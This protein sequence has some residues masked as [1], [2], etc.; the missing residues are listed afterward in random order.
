MISKADRHAQAAEL[1]QQAEEVAWSRPS[2]VTKNLEALSH[3]EMQRT[4]HEL[5]VHQIELEMQNEELCREQAKLDVARERCFDLYDLAPVGY[6]TISEQGLILEVNLIAATL[7]GMARGA[8]IKEPVSRFIHK[9]DQDIYYQHRKQLF[10]TGEPRTCELRMQKMDGNLFWAQLAATIEQNPST[11]SCQNADGAPVCRVVISDITDRKFLEDER[12]LT[13]RLI[14]LVNSPGD[15]SESMSPMVDSLQG[16]SGCDAVGIRLRAGDDYPYYDTRGF[17]PEFV[18]KENHLCVYGP[19]GKI[20]RD[21]EGNPVLECICG[22]I[23]CGRF[24]PANPFFTAHGSF[25]SN[26]TTA[27]LAGTTEAERQAHMRFRC[28]SEGYESM[29]LIPLRFDQQVF[30]L[31]QFNDHRPNRFTS[32]LIGH[33]E[34]MADSLAIALS[35]R[36]A[37]EELR[38]SERRLKEAQKMARLGHWIWDERTG[39]INWTGE[40][41]GIFGLDPK[42]FMPHIDSILALSPWPED[43]E[44]DKELYRKAMQSQENG[45]FEQRFLRPDQSI[46]YYHS[47]FQGKYDDGGNLISIVG[48][49]QDITE[50]KRAEEEKAKLEDQLQ[51]ARKMEAVGHLAGGVAHDFNNNLQVITTYVEMALM[52]LDVAHPFFAHLTEIRKAADRSANLTRQLLAFARKQVVEPKV[53]DLN[54]TVEGMLKML[55]RL[56]GENIDL[57]W[58]PAADL[59]PLK[60]D[61]S[62]IDQIL[63]NLCVNARDAIS[64]VGTIT[65]ET[66][67][68]TFDE[69]YCAD[70]PGF[71]PGEYLRLAVSDS[72]CGM[73]K[74][75]LCHIFEP[76]FTTKG[77]GEGTGLGLATVYGIVKQNNGFINVYSEPGQGSTFSIHLPCHA[78]KAEQMRLEGPATSS[79][80]NHE[81]ILLVE[82]DLPILEIAAAV[83]KSFGYSVLAAN[84]PG[85]AIRLAEEHAGEI[86]LLVTDVIMP[87]MNGRDLAKKLLSLYP[88]LKRLFMS[89]YTADVIAQRGMLDEGVHFIQKPFSNQELAVN[90]RMVLDTE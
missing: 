75:M 32:D 24:D 47:T 39:N 63:A 60:M 84:T 13:V 85:K 36:K 61:P 76:F 25:W 15:L 62:Q 83:L 73:D 56:I 80:L 27:L 4:F 29:A 46:G 43:H 66:R 90:V 6:C 50:L 49:V 42:D 33:F 72:G 20:L 1:R 52:E 54:E 30:G 58:Q 8:L 88:N 38:E 45:T 7:L 11:S 34:R 44:R 40:V 19:D 3:E 69:M 53:L 64:D 18:H 57:H 70:N 87:K 21:E 79:A 77:V 82:D 78:G 59:C 51:Q 26:N 41:F 67:K 9:E 14:E 65:I 22:N 55:Q 81:T 35:R 16:W 86:H 10:E 71:I 23:L 17:L 89:G 28:L 68:R 31:L 5:Q 2:A 12:E 74:E 48:T 37:A